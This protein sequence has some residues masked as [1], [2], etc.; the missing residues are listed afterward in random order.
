MQADQYQLQTEINEKEKKLAS[1]FGK[2]GRNEE[3]AETFESNFKQAMRE[4]AELESS[5]RLERDSGRT[6]QPSS[7]V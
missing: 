2:V 6:S 5:F 7:P 4:I 3:L 1:L